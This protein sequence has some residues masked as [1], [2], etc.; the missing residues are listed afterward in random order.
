MNCIVE[1]NVFLPTPAYML[2]HRISPNLPKEE[3]T[4]H[5]SKMQIDN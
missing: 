3:N 2:T 5:L 1:A 4:Q